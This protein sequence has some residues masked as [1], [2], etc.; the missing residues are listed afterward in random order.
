MKEILKIKGGKPLRGTVNVSGAKNAALPTIAATLLT[1]EEVVLNNVPPLKDVSTMLE[2]TSRLGKR[3][4]K[5]SD[6]SYRVS[7]ATKTTKTPPELVRKMRASFLVLGPLLGKMKEAKIAFPGGCSIGSRPIDFHLKGL[8]RLGANV[9]REDGMITASTKGLKGG[10]I[11]LDYPSVG[12]TEQLLMGAAIADG[13]TTVHNPAREPEVMDLIDLLTK[14]GAKIEVELSK[15][16]VEGV[17]KLHG[18]TH[19]I[20]PDRIE[21]G[22][23]L[24]A[25]AATGGNLKVKK[26][27]PDHLKSLI[28]K[29]REA[30]LKVEESEEEIALEYRGR[31]ESLDVKT[32]PYPGFPTD[33]QAPL[34]SL[35][36]KAEGKSMIRET[37][38][39]SRLD[40][41]PE[42]KK[43]GAE[44]SVEGSDTFLVKGRDELNGSSVEATD[45][46]AGAALVIAG[47]SAEGETKIHNLHH[48][49]RGY[50]EL[51]RK[52]RGL[53]AQ[54]E[55]KKPDYE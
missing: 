9:E 36:V 24:L 49:D 51:E 35:L 45:I 47:M 50:S 41:I 55:R 52:L 30:G 42:L 18:A 31:L 54:I 25:G 11:Y 17:E 3:I 4:E 33:L 14:L 27:N 53:D 10:E 43:M 26:I 15:I 7:E 32:F 5:I 34:T 39:D 19:S 38:F 13:R 46:R 16:K 2:M 1:D 28:I 20:V 6:H 37:I 29:L 21:A 12:A 8:S 48:L 23:Y 44:I 40:H 22:T